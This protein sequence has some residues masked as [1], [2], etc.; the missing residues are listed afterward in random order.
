MR[1]G[2]VEILVVE[3]VRADAERIREMLT[4]NQRWRFSIEHARYLA[5]ALEMLARK[6]F[7]IALVDLG[8]PD[9]RGLE[10]ALAIRDAAAHTPV[11]VLTA[12]RDEEAA[13][14][15]LEMDIQDYLVKGESTDDG[16]ALDPPCP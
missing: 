5:E 15:S 16:G 7:D 11:V 8:L 3:D 9:S 13:K 1:D 12:L 6:T 4:E 10:T 2:K 14:T